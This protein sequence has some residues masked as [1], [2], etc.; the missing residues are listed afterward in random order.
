MSVNKLTYL[1]HL[2]VCFHFCGLS[3]VLIVRKNIVPTNPDNRES[4]VYAKYDGI[5]SQVKQYAL[6][7]S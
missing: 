4:T 7:F 5:F 2:H 6:V 3:G 1:L